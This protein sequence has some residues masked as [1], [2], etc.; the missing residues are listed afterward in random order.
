[1]RST[2]LRQ[3]IKEEISKITTNKKLT[4][5]VET[6]TKLIENNTSLMNR[7]KTVNNGQE[8]NEFLEFIL[9]NINPKISSINKMKL[10][11]IIDQ[12]FK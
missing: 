7:I 5:D 10:K 11:G 1:M 9:N 12:R 4:S 2:E 8:L 6:L 3:I